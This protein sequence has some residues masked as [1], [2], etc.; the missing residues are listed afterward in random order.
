MS[1][2]RECME[3]LWLN[4]LC[5]SCRGRVKAAKKNGEVRS[6]LDKEPED[7]EFCPM[8]QK[9]VERLLERLGVRGYEE[10]NCKQ[11]GI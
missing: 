1:D 11:R 10:D 2:Y 6:L 5:S 8:Y 3:K 7:W 9:V 4:M